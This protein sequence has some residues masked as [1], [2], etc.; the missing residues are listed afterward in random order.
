MGANSHEDV[1][2]APTVFFGSPTLR[3]V[4]LYFHAG[5]H[6]AVV[7]GV[8]GGLLT[9]L[10]SGGIAWWQH[11]VLRFLLWREGS[12]PCRYVQM[13][14]E[15]AQCILLRKE[16]GGYRFIHD[17]FRDYIASLDTT[18]PAGSMTPP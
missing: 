17:L 14:D 10:L 8:T 18:V 9:F 16:G 12:I 6:Y 2:I 5:F 3:Y 13:L 15:D 7:F 11:W 4:T 1:S